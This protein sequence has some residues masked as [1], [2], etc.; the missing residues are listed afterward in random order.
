M[1]TVGAETVVMIVGTAA[2]RARARA[3]G[4]EGTETLTGTE[5]WMVMKR[6]SEPESMARGTEAKAEARGGPKA[7][8]PE[9][10]AMRRVWEALWRTQERFPVFLGCE[11]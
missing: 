1:K 9:T 2:R 7:M 4:M 3:T 6:V 8:G 11:S 5:G 10:G